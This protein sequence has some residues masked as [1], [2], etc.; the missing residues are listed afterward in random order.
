MGIDHKF[1][2]TS[3]VSIQELLQGNAIFRVPRFQRN[4]AWK[5]DRVDALWSD[6]T[7][8]FMLFRDSPD[9]TPDAEYL[10][11]SV[12]LVKGNNPAEFFIIDGQQR[13]STLTILFCVARD[14]IREHIRPGGHTAPAGIEK[15][16]EMI[17]N[18]TLGE[19]KNWKLELNDT[20]KS[21]FSQIQAY[22]EDEKTQARR[23]RDMPVKTPSERLLRD[24]YLFL[25]EKMYQALEAGFDF[26]DN[27]RDIIT[28][29][30]SQED[31][32]DHRRDNIKML[33]YFIAYIKEYNFVVKVMVKD[34]SSAFQIFETLN[35]R[36]QT[37]SKSNLIKNHILN[38]LDKSNKIAQQDLSDR[39]N[40]V[41]DE[42]I[43]QEQRD[44]AFIL[45]S[46]RSRHFSSKHKMSI[47]NLYKITKELVFDEK[48]CKKYIGD[49]EADAKFLTMLNDT[50]SY[51]DIDTAMEVD[52]MKALGA[53]SIRIPML[54]AY[55]RW[56][57]S[58]EYRQ[59][60]KFLVKFFFKFRTV[61]EKHP[62]R[63]DKIVTEAA[64]SI[65]NNHPLEDIISKIKKDDDHENFLYEFD[66]SLWSFGDQAKYILQQIS[67]YLDTPE[68][69]VR[70]IESL[71][72]ERI[73]PINHP[74]KYWPKSEI[75]A[76]MEDET[77]LDDYI[78]SIGNMTILKSAIDPD[79]QN[80]P[81][82]FKKDAYYDQSPLTINSMTVCTVSRWRLD[83]IMNRQ[84]KLSEYADEIWDLN[85][86]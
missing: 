59:L 11:G 83:T 57:F 78:D 34:D 32:D 37:L 68:D 7:E 23:F 3:A 50:S 79:K 30:K 26:S 36:G 65:V 80:M 67:L 77:D 58:D 48:S 14:I 40:K 45:E 10:L 41:F 52:A 2:N 19:H 74:E 82:E 28:K 8:N 33:N 20:D 44:D 35:E 12:V 47:K 85:V 75:F 76:N 6:I 25:Y 43:G 63:I 42:I 84:K 55:R 51:S 70:S 4:Y 61:R 49:L 1:S 46:L 54:A 86:F 56:G 22:E 29:G 60:V 71:A 64:K 27:A 15:I 16:N 66:R 24:N 21:L 9:H 31:L 18:T 53:K 81:F 38:K 17:E 62:G 72:L 13:L 39:W 5:K 73:L 69:D